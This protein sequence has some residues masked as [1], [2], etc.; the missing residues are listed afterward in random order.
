MMDL[1]GKTAIITGSAR[2]IGLAIAGRFASAGSNVVL[3]DLDQEA[4]DKAAAELKT[5][6]IGVKANVTSAADVANLFDK[7]VERF[8]SVDI[9]VNNAGILRDTSFAKMRDQVRSW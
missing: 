3:C 5:E 7:T 6:A 1:S 8:G 2:G 9:V 4:V